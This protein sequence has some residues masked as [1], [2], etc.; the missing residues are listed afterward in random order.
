MHVRYVAPVDLYFSQHFGLE[1]GLV[2]EYG[3]VDISLVS[4]LPLFIDPFLLFNSSKADYQELHQQILTYLR[5]LKDLAIAD[6]LTPGRVKYL[7]HFKEVRQNWFGFTVLGNGGSGLGARFA[8]ELRSNL[9]SVFKTFGEEQITRDS[10]LEKVALISGGVGRD[11]ISDFTTCLIKDYLARYTQTFAMEHL[12]EK[13]RASFAV[14]RASFNYATGTW[15]PR[16]YVLPIVREDF[17]LLTPADMLT[18][19]DTWISNSDLVRK[20]RH[21]PPTIDDDAL[22]E[23]VSDYFERQLTAQREDEDKNFAEAVYKTVKAYPELLDYY[24]RFKEDHG[25]EAK[26]ISADKVRDT[27]DI[28]IRQLKELFTDLKT[29]TDFF[30]TPLDSYQAALARAKAFKDYVE[31]NDGYQLINRKGE[32]FSNEKEVQLYFGLIWYGSL[33]DVNREV[34]NGRGPVDFKV[35][36]GSIDKTLIEFKLASNTALKRNLEKQLEIYEKANRTHKSVSVIISYT[37]EQEARIQ[38]ILGELG[39]T[40]HESVIVIDAR[41]DNKPSGSKA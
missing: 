1:D 23:S 5:Y 41:T 37:A 32:A 31:N 36:Y 15:E 33:F 20:F 16:T 28:F 6:Q 35:S 22:R 4:D 26:S 21:I 3:A 27:E 14:E 39:M 34:N 13:Q 7:F 18:K 24:I 2:E 12:D 8:A 40:S 29:K 9:R 17:V 25:D 19:D 30:D 10:H 38:R 11:G